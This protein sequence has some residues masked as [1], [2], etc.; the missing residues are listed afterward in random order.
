MNV[1]RCKMCGGQLNINDDSKIVECDYCGSVQTLPSFDNEKKSNLFNRANN[2]RLGK[3]FDK[4]SG[5][6]ESI[7]AEF[8]EE[9]EAYWGL[10]LCKYGIEYVDDPNTGKKI[11]TCHRTLTTSIMDDSDFELACENADMLSRNLYREEAK[12]IDALQKRILE[13]VSKEEPYDVFICYKETDDVTHQ[14]T[15]DSTIAQDIYT[16]LVKEGYKVFFSRVTLREKAG[17]EYEP[18]I[19]AALSSAKVMLA[20]G[21]KFEYYDAVWVKNE[22]SRYLAMMAK[23]PDK[24]LIPCYKN[25]DAYDMPTNFKNL[26][27]LDMSDVTF[28][29]NLIANIDGAIPKNK[30]MTNG[31]ANRATLTGNDNL[32]K[33]IALPN[34][35]L[36]TG[37]AVAGKPHGKGVC[38]YEK[39][40]KYEGDWAFGKFNGKGKYISEEG[41]SYEGEWKQGKYHGYGIC[42]YGNG[43]VYEGLFLNGK[44]NG[45]GKLI[46][47]DKNSW[48][49]VFLDDDPDTGTGRVFFDDGYYEGALEEG[50]MNGT[51]V[52]YWTDGDEWIGE[53][54]NGEFW[55]GTGTYRKYNDSYYVGE[56]SEGERNGKGT[57][58][59][60]IGGKWVGEFEDGHQMNGEG[61]WLYT[62]GYYE[63]VFVNGSREGRGTFFNSKENAKF[64]G[65][66]ENNKPYDGEWSNGVLVENGYNVSVYEQKKRK[67]RKINWCI[68]AVGLVLYILL[69]LSGS[70]Y[71]GA[72]I[73]GLSL[74]IVM[75]T[76]EEIGLGGLFAGPTAGLIFNFVVRLLF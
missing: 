67:K 65:T 35:G 53:F 30:T 72:A 68:F 73:C 8:P 31:K 21:T 38:I 3:E 51:G 46:Y 52:Y 11:S 63:G 4:A 70:S 10:C 16:E 39:G 66:Y 59:W 29:K 50:K 60:N 19:Y 28:F 9:A 15:E 33:E 71:W 41:N 49:G 22:W 43:D 58:Y 14:R 62:D 42:Q 7:V 34:G 18:Y 57:M 74:G 5:V 24:V 40:G 64:T 37:E 12:A 36:Y 25:I 20:V 47:R 48:E 1:F 55:K 26:Q 2:L 44:R 69:A 54:K 17:V 45:K 61:R 75:A 6:F 56:W 27:A 13:I 76:D 32:I 23:S